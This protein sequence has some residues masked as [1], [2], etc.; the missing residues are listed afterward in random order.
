MSTLQ[1]KNISKT[2]DSDNYAVENI[3]IDVSSGEFLVL[4]GP[5]G[6]GKSTILRM[7]AGLEEITSGDL[8][9]NNKNIN[10]LHP[11]NRNIGMV[12]QNYALYPHMSVKENLE[13]PLKIKKTDKNTIDSKVK[14]TAILVGINELLERKPKQLSGGQRQRVALGRALI[15]E[16]EIFLFDE[17]L[18]NLDAKLRAKMRLEIMN[19]HRKSNVISIYVTHDQV[20]AMT[21]ADKI[22]ILDNGK[23]QQVGSP[24][25]VYNDPLN[26]MVARFIGSPAINEI[27]GAIKNDGNNYSF[28]GHDSR[29]YV[30]L[31]NIH[32]TKSA[33]VLSIRP[34]HI[35]FDKTKNDFQI[36][37][38]ES[39][40]HENLVYVNCD[41]IISIRTKSNENL[42]IGDTV[43]LEIREENILFFDEKGY[44]IRF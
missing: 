23:I 18:S 16:P 44:R 27:P 9:F 13:F 2:Y 8:V 7:I 30:K 15:R 29:F 22:V 37:E 4:V 38:I 41:P 31:K 19:I 3:N 24:K 11:K 43:G 25:E 26:Q 32:E 39:L 5:S 6:C 10:D 21:M 40:G 33:I 36:I 34:E 20:E 14:E 1:L 28:E 12:F 42:K 17:P 35:Q